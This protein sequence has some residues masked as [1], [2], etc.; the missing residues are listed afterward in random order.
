MNILYVLGGTL[1]ILN[2]GRAID[3]SPRLRR[4]IHIFFFGWS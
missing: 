2:V 4:W 3:E 1:L